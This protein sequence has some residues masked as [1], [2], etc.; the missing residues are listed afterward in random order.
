MK[1]LIPLLLLIACSGSSEKFSKPLDDLPPPEFAPYAMAGSLSP[2]GTGPS[3]Q[4]VPAED[5]L[6]SGNLSVK[7]ELLGKGTPPKTL[8]LILRNPAGGPPIAAKRMQVSS[9]PLEFFISTENMM[10]PGT[11]IPESFLLEARLD[12]DG[13]AG[14][15][16]PGDWV[17]LTKSPITKG[18][19]KVNL[20]V[21][22][23]F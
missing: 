4:S 6:V 1:Y 10:I 14:K 23:I 18:Q 20:A 17:G 7:K 13:S 11:Q 9:F 3:T 15:P 19:T 5:V 12:R 2:K 8:F 16:E 21:D 22:Q